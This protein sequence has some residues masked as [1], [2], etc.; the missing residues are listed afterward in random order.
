MNATCAA[1]APWGILGGLMMAEAPAKLDIGE[2]YRKY[3]GVVFR[4][5]RRF[6]DANEAEEVVHEVFVRVLEKGDSFRRESSPVTWLYRVTTNLCLNRIRNAG[7]RRE[8]LE[9]ETP[10]LARRTIQA[11]DQANKA[12]VADLWS[13]LDKEL[14]IIGIYHYVDG[15]TNPEIARLIGCSPRTVVNR[16]QSLRA[17]VEALG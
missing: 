11:A 12:F 13:K 14:V 15:M 7:R 10:L 16:L 8:L 9:Q 6:F 17:Q 3:A 4:R 5:A 1:V 2:L